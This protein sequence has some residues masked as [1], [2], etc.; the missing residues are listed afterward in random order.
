MG[1]LTDRYVTATVR[2]LAPDQRDDVDRE[3]RGTIEDMVEARL[4]AGPTADRDEVE[5][6]VLVEL[7]DPM[8]LAAGYSGRPLHLIGPTVYPEWRRLVVLLVS[9]VVPLAAV[10]TLVVRLFTD[11]VAAD[12]VGPAFG[13]AALAGLTTAFHVVFWTTLVFAILERTQPDTGVMGWT[14]D[15]LPEAPVSRRSVGRSETVLSVVALVVMALALVWQRTSSPV[16][17]RGEAVPVLD[18]ALWSGWLPL[19]LGLLAAHAALALVAFRARRWTWPTVAVGVA[20]DVAVAALLVGLAQTDRL[21]A[22]GFVE[23]LVDGGWATAGR[24]LRV[25]TVLG[26]L[27]VTLWDQ[28]ETGRR[29]LSR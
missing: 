16:R 14:P 6:A 8:R 9:V 22:P 10:G 4:D 24:D 29:M 1:T 27:V 12:G 19:L 3:L 25:A 20:L 23:A 5:R 21:F 18:P 7:G 11:D 17:V 28:V 15:Q 2:E 26:V 13:G